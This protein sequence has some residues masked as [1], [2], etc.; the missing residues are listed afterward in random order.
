[1][2]ERGPRPWLL[3]LLAGIFAVGGYFLLPSVRVQSI[4]YNLVGLSSVAAIV[5][6]IRMHRPVRPLHWHVLALGMVVVNIGEAIFTFYESDL[7]IE[8]PFPSVADAFYLLA[9]PC[10]AVGLMLMHRR[11]VPER[12]WANLVDA[13]I[14]ATVAGM[15][16]WIFLM[17][18]NA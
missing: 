10:F 17:E 18:P 9:M 16:L 8:A 5:V 14:I 7:G 11:Q 15:L 3:Y 1:M 4:F 6:G 2:I 13:L 12:Q